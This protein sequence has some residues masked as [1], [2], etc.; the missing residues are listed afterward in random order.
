VLAIDSGLG[1]NLVWHVRRRFSDYRDVSGVWLPF[2]EDRTLD[3]QRDSH[4]ITRL[5]TVNGAVDMTLFVPP[6]VAAK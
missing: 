2:V 5:A 6:A 4:V 1:D 3:G